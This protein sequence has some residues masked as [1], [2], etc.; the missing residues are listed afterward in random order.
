M[1]IPNPEG[2]TSGTWTW[3]DHTIDID[4]A[5]EYSFAATFTPEKTAQ[6][7][8]VHTNLTVTI[9]KQ[10]PTAT[11]PTGL[12]ATA[13]QTLADVTLTNPTGITPGT[14]TWDDASTT[15][16]AAGEHT[17]AAIFT[18]SNTRTFKTVHT[19]LTV[20]VWGLIEF[21]SY[22]QTEV[23]DSDLTAA[24]NEQTLSWQSYGYYSKSDGQIVAGDFMEYCD[25][26]QGGQKYRGV[27]F[28]LYRPRATEDGASPVNYAEM[29]HQDLNGY[30]TNTIYWFRYEPLQWRV[31]DPDTGLLLCETVIDSQPYNN[32][33]LRADD[34]YYYGD[35]DH[36]YYANNYEK[37]SVRDWLNADFYN[38][39]FTNAQKS[40]IAET[41][42]VNRA[43]D[44]SHS[45]YDS[46]ST[47][48][49]VFLL[50]YSEALDPAYGFES[51]PDFSFTRTAQVSD[52]A[53][54]QGLSVFH[55]NFNWWL[56]SAGEYSGLACAVFGSD[57]NEAVV[58]DMCEED[59]LPDE[60]G[61]R[62]QYT[63]ILHTRR[64]R[65][66]H[67]RVSEGLSAQMYLVP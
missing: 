40:K 17:F 1:V 35:A 3:D 27:R 19:D 38:T 66:S 26:T 6:F 32:F 65:H 5:G 15:L 22:P 2:N 50:S 67:L 7:D 34:A 63:E 39:A 45:A 9:N 57:S 13:G 30:Y 47:T 28:S 59:S 36:S 53:K 16:S 14:W 56:R 51:D 49:K 31:L 52:Y 20:T 37:S 42:L 33:M 21:G 55:D 43:F 10:D 46:A 18:P 24:L 62:I 60:Y 8:T 48:D 44:T 61:D 58:T 4:T 11:P 23:K 41:T 64:R 25:V 54:C 29:Y 12:T